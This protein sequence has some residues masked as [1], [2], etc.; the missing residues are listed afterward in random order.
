MRQK[1]SQ[2]DALLATVHAPQSLH[3]GDIYAFARTQ[4]IA[5]ER[6]L[7]FSASINPL[8]MPRRALTA[9]RHAPSR[10]IHYPEPYA[11]SLTAELAAYH[12]LAPGAILVG[13]GSTQL[14][15]LL[16][17]FLAARRV[18]LVSPLFSEHDAAFRGSGAR[19]D[20]F[21]LRPPAFIFSPE[22][23]REALTRGYDA[24]VLTNPN[25]PTG[26]A[27]SHG[28][29]EE[30]ARFCRRIRTRL[31]V[32]ETFVDW[33]EEESAKHLAA[34]NSHV[35]VLR[36]LTKFFAVPGLRV[37]YLITHPQLVARLRR[38][39]EPWSVNT[40]AQTVA[41]ACL[42]EREFAER[43]RAFLTQEREW[44]FAQLATVKGLHSFLSRANFL[45]VRI[46]ARG[47]D[48]PTVARR[49]AAKNLLVRDC[50][51]FPGLGR[52][53]FRV[54]VRTRRENRRLLRAL[55]A[56]L[57]EGAGGISLA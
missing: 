23:M 56:L 43:S 35:I 16:A 5:P 45:L 28:Q 42:Q 12:G 15:F 27:L 33:I 29:I 1:R 18:L 55:Q 8:G 3:G 30:V 50:T 2:T 52:K 11:E 41:L 37:G 14:I 46:T 53:F 20:R 19:I 22:Q 17:R 39:L 49:L 54:A 21:F 36:S 40:V 44:L 26:A 57:K 32:D 4:E 47:Y 25:S 7:D 31:I 38:H 9:Y 51:N 24:L 10:I 13:N 34:R 6:V 48:A